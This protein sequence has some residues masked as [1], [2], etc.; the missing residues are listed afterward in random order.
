M[1]DRAAR[2]IDMTRQSTVAYWP[3]EIDG[4]VFVMFP[5]SLASG[6]SSICEVTGYNANAG[7]KLTVEELMKTAQW[8]ADALN[9]QGERT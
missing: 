6:T 5:D 4:H 9:A 3:S 7:E 2:H 8:I 1:T